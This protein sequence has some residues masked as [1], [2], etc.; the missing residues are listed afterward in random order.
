MIRRRIVLNQCCLS[1]EKLEKCFWLLHMNLFSVIKS[2]TAAE[3]VFS[4]W[5]SSLLSLSFI[6]KGL[7]KLSFPLSPAYHHGSKSP[8]CNRDKPLSGLIRLFLSCPPPFPSRFYHVWMFGFCLFG[9][10]MSRLKVIW[11][12]CLSKLCT[13]GSR[14]L[15]L[16]VLI[17][18]K[19]KK[20][21]RNLLAGS[22]GPTEFHNGDKRERKWSKEM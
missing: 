11:S 12:L 2:S 20:Q 7:L 17:K 5:L 21:N 14:I 8:E 13:R 10:W 19:T 6:S 3:T 1:N 16:S 15:S 9:L 18:R 22:S 4:L